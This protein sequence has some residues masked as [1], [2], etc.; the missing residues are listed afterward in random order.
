MYRSH[1][2]SVKI[3]SWGEERPPFGSC[4]VPGFGCIVWSGGFLFLA[5]WGDGGA[6]LF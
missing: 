4:E 1:L 2:G 5:T 3:S 6:G